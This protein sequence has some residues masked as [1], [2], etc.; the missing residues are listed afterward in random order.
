[1]RHPDLSAGLGLQLKSMR[2]WAQHQPCPIVED[3]MRSGDSSSL[4]PHSGVTAD[5]HDGET[6]AEVTSSLVAPVTV[7]V[8]PS[9]ST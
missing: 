9:P 6:A 8:A 7:P 3:G 4:I 5:I 1:M 2:T